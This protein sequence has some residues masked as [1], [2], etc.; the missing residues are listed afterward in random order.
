M[1]DEE[2]LVYAKALEEPQMQ[3]VY[4]L[5]NAVQFEIMANRF[6]EVAQRLGT[7]QPSQDL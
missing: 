2:V 7:M 4:A 1:S 5:M 3:E 6:E